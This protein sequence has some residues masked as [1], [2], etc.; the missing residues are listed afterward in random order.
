MCVNGHAAASAAVIDLRSV[1]TAPAC[2][3]AVDMCSFSVVWRLS[4][5]FAL[6]HLSEEL[7]GRPFVLQTSR[8]P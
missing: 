2:G 8:T 7:F 5:Q 6:H 3:A 4:V 1:Q